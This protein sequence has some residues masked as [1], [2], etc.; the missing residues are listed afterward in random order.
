MWPNILLNLL[1]WVHWS[2]VTKYII[3]VPYKIQSVR[4]PESKT[5]TCWFVVVFE[6]KNIIAL[7]DSGF[8]ASESRSFTSSWRTHKT[9]RVLWLPLAFLFTG[10]KQK[11]APRL[12]FP[13]ARCADTLLL[14]TNI[15]KSQNKCSGI[16]VYLWR[17]GE[18][19]PRA[20]DALV[21]IYYA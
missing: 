14:S 3:S 19:N 10:G 17:W 1:F 18:S 20:D 6:Y 21:G 5:Q 8:I 16:F 9:S 12:R 7:F 15:Q 2:R 11:Y 4:Y 13:H